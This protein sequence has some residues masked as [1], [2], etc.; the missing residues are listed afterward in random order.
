[1]VRLKADGAVVV[2]C[3]AKQGVPRFTLLQPSRLNTIQ[4]HSLWPIG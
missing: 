4:N 2:K 3:K 1:V